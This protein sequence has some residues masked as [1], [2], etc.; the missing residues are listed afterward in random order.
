MRDRYKPKNLALEVVILV[1]ALLF[2]LPLYFIIS[3]SIKP[4]NEVFKSA[5]EFTKTP[6]WSNF[7]TVWESGMASA[8]TNSVLITVGSVVVLVIIGAMTSYALARRAGKLSAG[9]YVM[10]LLGIIVPFQLSV[11]PIY[12]TFQK[13][14][15]VG[16]IAGMITLWSGVMM[17]MSVILY[18][19]FVRQLPKEYEEAARIDGLGTF[20]IF[21][22]IV[23]P[24]LRPITGAVAIITGLFIWNDFY[25]SLIFLG[26]SQSKTLPVAIYSFVGEYVSRWNLVFAAILVAILPLIIFFILAQKQ[27]IKGFAGGMKG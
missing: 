9:L 13:I 23:F 10:F 19:G 4:E 21:S 8:F 17:P 11:V 2:C 15:L 25:G 20:M 7:S 5:L 24:L 26:G 27:M 3:I 22:R 12:T 16:N 1:V 14:G 18:T 6:Q